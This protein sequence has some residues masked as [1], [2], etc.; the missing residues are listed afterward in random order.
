MILFIYGGDPIGS[1]K[2][3]R[4]N[5]YKAVILKVYSSVP[6]ICQASVGRMMS[7]SVNILYNEISSSIIL[8]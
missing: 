4:I 3:R 1:S 6:E 8:V 5:S 7:V 2:N